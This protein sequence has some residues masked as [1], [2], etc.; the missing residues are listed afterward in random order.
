MAT[1]SEEELKQIDQDAAWARLMAKHE[2]K[3]KPDLLKITLDE[4]ERV[5]QERR[6]G[7]FKPL[8]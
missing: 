6:A 7:R 1:L 4:I 2:F 3:D 5:R 8:R